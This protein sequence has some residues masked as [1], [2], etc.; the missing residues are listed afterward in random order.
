MVQNQDNPDIFDV[1]QAKKD[2]K[3]SLYYQN[4]QKKLSINGH[5]LDGIFNKPNIT[6]KVPIPDTVDKVAIG[7]NRNI[8]NWKTVT[9]KDGKVE[10]EVDVLNQDRFNTSILTGETSLGIVNLLGMRIDMRDRLQTFIDK[11]VKNFVQARSHNLMVAKFAQFNVAVTGQILTA[12]GMSS[13]EI[14]KLQKE[15]LKSA[16][17]ENIQMFTENEYNHEMIMVV[18]GNKREI[19]SQEKVINE[20]RTQFITQMQRL[21]ESNYYTA[22]RVKEIQIEQLKNII[23]SFYEE[24]NNLEFQLNYI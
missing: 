18:G 23:T 15:A 1:T 20:M 5:G 10:L 19:Q 22:A 9:D 14:E 13:S 12:L 24:K 11:Y 6:Q 21:G 7:Q 16:V 3:D 4:L 2:I 8:F 17:N